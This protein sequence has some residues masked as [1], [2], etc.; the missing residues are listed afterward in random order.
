MN[1]SLSDKLVYTLIDHS[2]ET[3]A[4]GLSKKV[5]TELELL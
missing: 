5:R 1:G 4:R 2:Y 3:V